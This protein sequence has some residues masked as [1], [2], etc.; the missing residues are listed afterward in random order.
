MALP[1]LHRAHQGEGPDR[2]HGARELRSSDGEGEWAHGSC[3]RVLAMVA[4][5]LLIICTCT[6]LC[7][8]PMTGAV[9]YGSE[10]FG[11]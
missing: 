6:C 1:L 3:P 5:D 2:V 4:T 7:Q 11:E 10:S 8:D 9:L